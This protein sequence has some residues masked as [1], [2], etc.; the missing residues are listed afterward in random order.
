MTD[1]QPG[2]GLLRVLDRWARENEAAVSI[3]RKI[4][5]GHP[6]EGEWLLMSNFSREA[7]DS[8]MAG[9]SLIGAHE[10]LDRCIEQA[11]ADARINPCATCGWEETCEDGCHT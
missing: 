4:A 8:P 1:R 10:R 6:L 11:L 2:T 3:G 9:G 7:P 5:E